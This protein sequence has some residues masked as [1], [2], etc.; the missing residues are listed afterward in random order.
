M[1]EESRLTSDEVYLELRKRILEHT[2]PPASKVNIRALS[3]ELGVS[4]TPVREALRQLQGDNLLVGTSNKGYTTTDVLDAR[5][6]RELFEFRLLVE[7]WAA[8]AAAVNRLSNPG[9]TLSAEVDSFDPSAGPINLVMIRHDSAFHRT[10][11]QATDNQVMIDAYQRSH[12]HLHLFR[13]FRTD[14]DWKSSLDQHREIARAIA[15]ADPDAAQKAMQHHLQQ[16]YIG[17]IRGL[18]NA[19]AEFLAIPKEPLIPVAVR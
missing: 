7:P 14:W 2:M 8:A 13:A 5:G 9:H 6:V 15:G 11:L 10:I 3:R 17:F 18:T 19:E 1:S 4:S 12:C 16:A